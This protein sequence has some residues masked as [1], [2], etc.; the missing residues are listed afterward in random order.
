MT[1]TGSL[2]HFKVIFLLLSF[3]FIF[4]NAHSQESSK[5]LKVGLLYEPNLSIVRPSSVLE[6]NPKFN[7]GM[8]LYFIRENENKNH[9]F[10]YGISLDQNSSEKLNLIDNRNIVDND[11]N[12]LKDNQ[13]FYNA[14]VFYSYLALSVNYNYKII[15]NEKSTFGISVG[16][17]LKYFFKYKTKY[18][19]HDGQINS[20]IKGKDLVEKNYFINNPSLNLSFWYRHNFAEN[21]A[22]LV[23]TNYSYDLNFI[24]SIP[25]YHN[26]GIAFGFVKNI[27]S[28]KS[29]N[30]K[31]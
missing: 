2:P 28:L 5:Q 6:T 30:N 16:P 27:N 11:G 14:N 10:W 29:R 21:W 1:T 26:I 31:K 7:Y 13:R 20:N 8:G 4:T 24:T 19:L 3:S 15:N 18:N 23:G 9:F 12:I 17:S 22:I 25:K